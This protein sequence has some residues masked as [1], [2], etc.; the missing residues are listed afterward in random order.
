MRTPMRTKV[1]TTRTGIKTTRTAKTPI[2][3]IRARTMM[4]GRAK[5]I[6]NTKVTLRV[7]ASAVM[8]TK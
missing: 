3:T 8:T 5:A 7:T 6:A 2:R 4:M 1:T